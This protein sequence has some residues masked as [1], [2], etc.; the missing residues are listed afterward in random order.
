VRNHCVAPGARL[1]DQP[2]VGARHEL[3]ERGRSESV[4][5]CP[6]SYSADFCEHI[7]GDWLDERR[8]DVLGES[9]MQGIAWSD[10]V[11]NFL[12]CQPLAPFFRRALVTGRCGQV[13]GHS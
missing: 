6:R 1:R 10:L 5:A 12:N 2:Q 13:A 4:T 9:V 7:L 3:V 11:D 8:R